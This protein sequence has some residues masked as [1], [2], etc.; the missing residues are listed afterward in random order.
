MSYTRGCKR[1][2][3]AIAADPSKRAEAAEDFKSRVYARTTQGPRDHKLT[4]WEEVPVAAGHVDPFAL[5]SDTLYDVSAILWK[6]GYRSLDS[7][8]TMVR[9]EL[10]HTHGSLP[11]VFALHFKCISRAAARGRGPAKQAGTLLVGRLAELSEDTPPFSPEGPC[12]PS[13]QS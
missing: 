3:L 7:Y 13:G 1:T 12:F 2:A 9:Q 4:T 6:A 5:S 11:E 8:L 10:L